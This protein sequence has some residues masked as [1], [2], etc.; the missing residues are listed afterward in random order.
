VK[1]TEAA[2]ISQGIKCLIHKGRNIKEVI[3]KTMII[4]TRMVFVMYSRRALYGEVVWGEVSFFQ[5]DWRV[6]III[7]TVQIRI[8][9]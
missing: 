3:V 4:I 6:L 7:K 2:G 5:M 1:K 9:A 8:I